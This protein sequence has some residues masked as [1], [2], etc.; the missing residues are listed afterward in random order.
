MGAAA[1]VEDLTPVVQPQLNQLRKHLAETLKPP[2]EI[3]AAPPAEEPSAAGG[4]GGTPPAA[5]QS[6]PSEEE[7][8]AAKV[9][10]FYLASEPVRPEQALQCMPDH[11]ALHYVLQIGNDVAIRVCVAASRGRAQTA[12]VPCPLPCCNQLTS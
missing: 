2:A 8:A 7:L 1:S 4:N 12:C 10:P 6:G 9:F 11:A 5:K 3:L